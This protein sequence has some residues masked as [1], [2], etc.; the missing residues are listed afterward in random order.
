MPRVVHFEIHVSE[1]EKAI[2]FYES[3]FGWKFSHWAGHADY[4][5]ITTGADGEPGINGGMMR[6][7]GGPPAPGQAVNSYVCTV[8]VDSVDAYVSKA[9]SAGA[10]VCVPKMPIPGVGWVAYAT[11]PAGNI[12]GI[13]QHDA[14]AK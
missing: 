8:A 5:L 1:P 4:W 11:D 12:F 10:V 3:V 7:H 13:Y 6:R 14:T 2:A 9:T